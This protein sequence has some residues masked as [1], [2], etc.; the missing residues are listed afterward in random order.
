MRESWKS[1]LIVAI[2]C[3]LV[4]VS[5]CFV[6]NKK[7]E[8]RQIPFTYHIVPEENLTLITEPEDGIEPILS[9]IQEAST[10]IDVVM[11]ELE[12]EKVEEELAAA[13]GRGVLVRVILSRGLYGQT[14]K[15][16]QAAFSYFQTHHVQ[17][18]WSPA[19]F[20]LTHQKTIIIDAHTAII[21]T[22]NLTPAYYAA[23][24][25]FAVID[26]NSQDVSSIEQTFTA[27]WQGTQ[28][29]SS[30]AGNVTNESSGDLVWSP[31]SKQVF[32]EMIASAKSTIEV[33]SEE[34]QDPDIIAGLAAA[35]GRGVSVSL[36]MTNSSEWHQAFTYLA[37]QGVHIRTYPKSKHSLYI[38]E[39]IIIVDGA[40]AFLGSQNLTTTSLVSNRELGILVST[41]RIVKAIENVFLKDWSAAPD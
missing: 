27:D 10:S 33:T 28:S 32:L 2:L 21:M 18:K 22:F 17:V 37:S 30:V 31:N 20:A 25:D 3:V 26:D 24:R 15:A 41:P 4:V 11:Y 12:D 13:A 35:A 6:L 7:S 5:F 39:K 36:L 9:S 1:Y 8:P 16:H 29:Q 19:Y 38:H 23:A 40:Q 14:S 34:I